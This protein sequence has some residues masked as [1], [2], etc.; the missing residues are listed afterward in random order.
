MFTR[1]NIP[2]N[3]PISINRLVPSLNSFSRLCTTL[4]NFPIN[5]EYDGGIYQGM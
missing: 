1:N 5:I 4:P 3:N 2:S